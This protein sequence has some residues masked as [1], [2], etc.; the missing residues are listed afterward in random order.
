MILQVHELFLKFCSRKTST[1]HKEEYYIPM[2]KSMALCAGLCMVMFGAMAFT[3]SANHSWGGYHWART[4]NPFTLK[5]GSNLSTNWKTYLQTTSADWSAS[6]VL[7]TT[8]VAGNT[9]A[10]KGK[11]T[12]KNCTPTLGR[13]EVCNERYG[14]NGWLGIAS[15][16]ASGTHITQGTVKMNDSYFNSGFYNTP[17]WR[18]LVMCQEVGHTLGL[19]HQDETFANA[20]LGTCMDYTN[21]PATN[22]HPNQHDYDMLA[23]IYAHLDSS[24][25]VRS[26]TA[27]SASADE[28]SSDPKNWG[29]EVRRSADGRA[30]VFVKDLG[31]GNKVLRHVFWAE[32]RGKSLD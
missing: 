1:S 11:N 3:A 6:S 22:Q 17:A 18:N 4:S 19:D 21:D 29:Q 28:D 23:E 26:T 10:T 20:N 30:S 8:V 5:L 7:D 9:S 24:T 14:S 27:S 32:P 13:V 31:N 2:T 12:P 15:V 16:W 25:T